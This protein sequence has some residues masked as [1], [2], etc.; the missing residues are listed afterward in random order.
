MPLLWPVPCPKAFL[1][2]ARSMKTDMFQKYQS[3][4]IC[5]AT[6]LPT[7]VGFV[8]LARRMLLRQR[9]QQTGTDSGSMQATLLLR[10]RFLGALQSN[11]RS[12]CLAPYVR[13]PVENSD[14]VLMRKDSG[15]A[16]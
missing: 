10:P 1:P 2:A 11:H 7:A 3:P 8:Q 5:L 9:C 4:P 6:N 15:G 14:G 13:P 12:C 16:Q